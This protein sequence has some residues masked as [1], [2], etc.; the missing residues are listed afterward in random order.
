M[1]LIDTDI[2]IWTLRGN[3]QYLHILDK[4]RQKSTLAISTVTIA[5]V[6]KNTYPSEMIRTEEVLNEYFV[7]DVSSMIAK[8]GGLYWQYYVRKFKNLSILDCI[9]AATAREHNLAILTLNTRH[10]PM[11]DIQAFN[12]VKRTL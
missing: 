10:F 5:E 6:Y 9:I 8:Q 12:P 11:T 1:Y 4:L 7:W 2:V 3:R